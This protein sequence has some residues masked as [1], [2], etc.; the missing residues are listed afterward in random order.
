MATRS[1]MHSLIFFAGLLTG[2]AFACLAL[3][4]YNR[5]FVSSGVR[6]GEPILP[7]L[8][9]SRRTNELHG[10]TFVFENKTWTSGIATSAASL[11]VR[12]DGRDSELFH[13]PYSFVS[14]SVL[15]TNSC[16]KIFEWQSLGDGAKTRFEY[17]I[18]PNSESRS[19]GAAACDGGR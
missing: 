4:A 2:G 18:I 14:R 11:F 12:R 19:P 7:P 3:Q 13:M 10:A 1:G 5:N 16:Y 15:V 8:G 17:I 9:V 6:S